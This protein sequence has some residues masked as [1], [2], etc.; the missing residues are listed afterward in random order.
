MGQKIQV[1]EAYDIG[2]SCPFQSIPS[3]RSADE[4]EPAE[5]V[6]LRS[7]R[8]LLR[9]RSQR[10]QHHLPPFGPVHR[11]LALADHVPFVPDPMHSTRRPL[12][13]TFSSFLYLLE[14]TSA[15]SFPWNLPCLSQEALLH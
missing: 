8:L 15:W 10:H 11:V 5:P 13:Q 14:I 6:W 1:W 9:P 3:N 4:L 12:S 7:V 2:K